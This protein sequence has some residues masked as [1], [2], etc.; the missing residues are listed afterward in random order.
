VKDLAS[1]TLSPER[2]E[3]VTSAAWAADGKT[4]FYVGGASRDQAQL[5]PAPPRAG[6]DGERAVYE[7]KDELYD[8]GVGERAARKYIVM[9]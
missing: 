4:L 2:I 5:P 9:L 3:R 7:E 1:G 6:R 8:I